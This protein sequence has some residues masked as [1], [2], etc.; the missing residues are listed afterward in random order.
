[1]FTAILLACSLDGQCR[2]IAGPAFPTEDQCIESIQYV[3]LILEEKSPHMIVKDAKCM[4][5][6]E[7]A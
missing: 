7:D 2:G 5:W 6:G 1:M 4:A 3:W